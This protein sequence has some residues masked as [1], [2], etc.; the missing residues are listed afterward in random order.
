MEEPGTPSAPA[1]S[2]SLELDCV[3]PNTSAGATTH[4]YQ[5]LAIDDD[6]DGAF[7]FT[8]NMN[9]ASEP[10]SPSPAKVIAVEH[11]CVEKELGFTNHGEQPGWV[12]QASADVLLTCLG[13]NKPCTITAALSQLRTMI[14]DQGPGHAVSSV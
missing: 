2:P 11:Q 5:Y 13:H 9:F 14:T 10:R 6:L 7:G 12:L 4:T 1:G 8:G 3:Q